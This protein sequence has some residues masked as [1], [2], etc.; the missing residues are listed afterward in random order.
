MQHQVGLSPALNPAATPTL[1]PT[2]PVNV[3]FVLAQSH[4]IKPLVSSV[5][6]QFQLSSLVICDN[7]YGSQSLKFQNGI[8]FQLQLLDM[9]CNTSP[10]KSKDFQLLM[11]QDCGLPKTSL[12]FYHNVH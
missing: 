12:I 7:I 11:V 5:L 4:H 2:K 3:S 10:N 6:T 8:T 1:M 9:R